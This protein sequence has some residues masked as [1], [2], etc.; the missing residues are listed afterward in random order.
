MY[1]QTSRCGYSILCDCHNF[2]SFLLWKYSR[3]KCH[4]A[5]FSTC[6][7][8]TEA[9]ECND[10]LGSVALL[11]DISNLIFALF[12]HCKWDATRQQLCLICD[13][14]HE[15]MEDKSKTIKYPTFILISTK[16]T[17]FL[18]PT[19]SA[20]YNFCTLQFLHPTIS[21]PY[22]FCTLQFL[23]P[24]IQSISSAPMKVGALK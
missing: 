4:A 8:T 9:T 23:H 5:E 1:Y 22:N 13:N 19:V 16:I 12:E 18:H 20:P 2:C 6:L 10:E 17:R 15:W 7:P 21:A 14:Q 3:T 11:I 24:T